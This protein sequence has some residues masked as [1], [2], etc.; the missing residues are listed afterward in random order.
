MAASDKIDKTDKIDN[1]DPILPQ[2]LALMDAHSGFAGFQGAVQHVKNLL[3]SDSGS[4]RQFASAILNDASLTA[5][6]LRLSNVSGVKSAYG[7][8]NVSTIDQALFIMGMDSMKSLV[9][10]LSATDTLTT[11][12]QK[13]RLEAEL[14]AAQFC[15]QLC[16]EITR[17]NGPH[18][19]VQE[20]QVCGLLQNL[21]RIMVTYYLYP[22]I[23]RS[24]PLQAYL[25]LTSDEAVVRTL[26]HDFE[27]IGAAV[28]AHWGLPDV[29]QKSIGI[30]KDRP[31]PRNVVT[32][33]EW[34]QYCALYA[35][36]VTDILFRL[37][38]SR[39]RIEVT[40]ETEYFR[41]VLRLK[42]FEVREWIQTALKETSYALKENGITVD[43]AR[44]RAVLRKATERVHDLLSA[45]DS[46]DQESKHL[47]S[48]RRPIDVFQQV[49]RQFHDK[50]GF[51]RS[52]LCL[53]DGSSGLVAVAG[54]G[55]NAG[56]IALRFR[57]QGIR[58]DIF[59][60]VFSMKTDLY[61][62]DTQAP[63]F[64]KFIPKWFGGL[65]GAG[66]MLLLPLVADGQPVGLLYGDY[67]E[68]HPQPPFDSSVEAAVKTWRNQLQE[69][70]HLHGVG[71]GQETRLLS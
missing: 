26:G 62:D 48:G 58:A 67:D 59:R 18:Y 35:R 28:A 55:R 14:V 36:R 68:I 3:D 42:D 1:V 56:S 19:S 8:G 43:V 71:A 32:P 23:E 29:L 7:K 34:H 51:D 66:S 49:L 4:A 44:A 50:Y 16:A 30:R 22:E 15:G 13:T 39:E 40:H 31:P 41:L 53:P 63:H 33:L 12:A 69:I 11:P 45:Q 6:V 54:V 17:I 37:P 5:Q 47:E 61:V 25:N 64:A 38:E 52:F 9:H 20:A 2:L 10:S 60:I 70:L 21:G 57:C 46:L 27:E 65:V 24:H